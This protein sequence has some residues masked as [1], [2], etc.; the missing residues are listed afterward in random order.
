[1]LTRSM[2]PMWLVW[3]LQ[4]HHARLR[5]E[6]SSNR[7][8]WE[9]FCVCLQI[10]HRCLFTH[11]F[12]CNNYV[13]AT[14]SGHINEACF[15]GFSSCHLMPCIVQISIVLCS[16]SVE[17]PVQLCCLFEYPVFRGFCMSRGLWLNQSMKGSFVL[18][19]TD[20]CA[21]CSLNVHYPIHILF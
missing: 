11:C 8:L 19:Q 17:G 15:K 9:T 20:R 21:F 10:N 7:G 5:K 2:L 3:T 14:Y 18:L 4:W 12:Y 6:A 13:C 16:G 1:M